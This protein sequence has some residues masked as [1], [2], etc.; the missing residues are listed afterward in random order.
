MRDLISN[1]AAS[2]LIA[3]AALDA[4]NTPAAVSVAGFDGA[5]IDIHVGIGGITV[6]GTNKVEFKLTHGDAAAGA[7]TAVA[8]ADVQGIDAV[9]TGGIIK[10]L[11]TA[12]AAADVTRVGYIGGKAFLKLL[13]DFGGTH[14]SPTPIAAS[15]TL[16]HPRTA[17]VA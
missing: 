1:T 16:A 3:A 17:P 4:D 14:A 7:F 13:A 5:V 12:H 11:I 15:V 8:L 2:I 10:S 9:G 6:T